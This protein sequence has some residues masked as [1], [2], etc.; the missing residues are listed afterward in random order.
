M[1]T[2]T[3]FSIQTFNSSFSST[4]LLWLDLFWWPVKWQL[5]LQHCSAKEN[6]L[7]MTFLWR[8][9]CGCSPWR[10]SPQILS[11]WIKRPGCTSLYKSPKGTP[12]SSY[13]HLFK[14]EHKNSR[15]RCPCAQ[16][17]CTLAVIIFSNTIDQNIPN[18]TVVKANVLNKNF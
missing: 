2:F 3:T 8:C 5:D 4:M 14:I 13:A 6:L 18:S 1:T 15:Y 11:L 7:P 17:R 16:V 12:T 10:S 9:C